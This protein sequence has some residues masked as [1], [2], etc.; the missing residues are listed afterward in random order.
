[1]GGVPEIAGHA[2]ARLVPPDRPDELAAALAA[3]LAERPEVAEADR[4]YSLQEFAER[5]TNVVRKLC[6]PGK[7]TV[8]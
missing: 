1:M 5:V 4:P 6:E 8:P 3:A 7:A 2:A